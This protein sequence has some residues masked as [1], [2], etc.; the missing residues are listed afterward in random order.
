[1]NTN[2]NVVTTA[3][4]VTH[5][6]TRGEITLDRIYKSDFQK[7][8]TMTAQLR[9]LVKTVSKYPS[10]KVSSEMQGN[11][12]A[13]EDFGFGTQD[14][15]SIET[16]IAWILVPAN[17]TEDAVKAKI[18]EANKNG[19]VLYRVLS[20]APILD[21]NQRYAIN[22]G[23]STKDVFANSQASR[24]PETEKTLANGT[25][26][27]LILDKAGNVQYRKIYFWPT[28]LDD[29]DARGKEIYLSPELQAE[30][31]GAS[32]MQGQGLVM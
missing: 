22:A 25:A 19:A 18:A 31:K 2:S 28:Q 7:A 29:Q 11:F 9:Q 20:N 5:T 16:R 13:V 24:Y 30:L 1:M 21:E 23:L 26:G 10:K 32:V 15:E 14:F 27:K 6:T 12:F 4:G 8:G 17:A 3:T